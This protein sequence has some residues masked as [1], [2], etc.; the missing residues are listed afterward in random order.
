MTPD[1]VGAVIIRD[2]KILLVSGYELD[3]YWT[4]GGRIEDDEDHET[5]LRREL[6]EELDVELVS[7]TPFV[8]YKAA[9]ETTGEMRTVYIYFA[10]ISGEPKPCAEIKSL[11]WYGI[12][13]YQTKQPTVKEHTYK[14]V[15]RH[16]AEHGFL[17]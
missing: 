14:K 11:A 17:H 15:I 9:R 16:L 5:T 7:M 3:R 2:G 12:D 13:N 1:R 6:K 8:T 10:D 4:P